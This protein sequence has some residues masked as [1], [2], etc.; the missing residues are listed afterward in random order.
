[1]WGEGGGCVIKLDKQIRIFSRKEDGVDKV[2][3]QET[4]KIQSTYTLDRVHI[5]YSEYIYSYIRQ[6][7]KTLE[8]V[9]RQ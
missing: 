4:E 1:M 6:S 7:T 5:H 8:G 2:Q 3:R 9:Q